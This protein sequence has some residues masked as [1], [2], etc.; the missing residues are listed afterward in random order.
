MA[1][2]P[3]GDFVLVDCTGSHDGRGA[4]PH[5][6]DHEPFQG[7]LLSCSGARR[8]PA[9][10]TGSGVSIMRNRSTRERRSTAALHVQLSPV[11]RAP[12]Y[13]SVTM[14]V[15][16]SYSSVDRYT[17]SLNSAVTPARKT[18]VGCCF[19]VMPSLLVE[20]RSAGVSQV[21]GGFSLYSA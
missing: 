1:G 18:G 21:R 2:S 15:R 8:T 10:C 16:P 20:S 11:A 4:R 13:H 9:R 12:E 5:V 3:C 19:Q 6:G 17:M 7:G 14:S